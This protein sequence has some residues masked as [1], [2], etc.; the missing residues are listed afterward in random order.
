MLIGD[1]PLN[2][3]IFSADIINTN[4]KLKGLDVKQRITY[5]YATV[6]DSIL[7]IGANTAL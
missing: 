5:S 1:A 7:L 2:N 3:Q 6:F 4:A